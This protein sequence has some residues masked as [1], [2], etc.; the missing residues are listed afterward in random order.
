[1]NISEYLSTAAWK[2]LAVEPVL[3][4]PTQVWRERP[5]HIL[6]LLDLAVAKPDQDLLV[7]GDRRMSFATF[8]KALEAGAVA[9]AGLGVAPGARVLIVMYN[10]AEFLL[11]QWTAWRVGA[12]PVALG[13]GAETSLAREAAVA[14]R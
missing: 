8:R 11:A 1:M 10:S 14:V 5:R 13:G 7:Q 6:D 9:M 4:R 2:E 12:V 3:G